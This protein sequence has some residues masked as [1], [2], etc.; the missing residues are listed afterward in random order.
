ME[1]VSQETGGISKGMEEKANV[2]KA[3][4]NINANFLPKNFIFG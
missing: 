3:T 1:K 2:E 4:I